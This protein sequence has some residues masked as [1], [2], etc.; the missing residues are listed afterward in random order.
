VVFESYNPGA[1][2]RILED[3]SAEGQI[4]TGPEAV[5]R[6]GRQLHGAMATIEPERRL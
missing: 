3:L 5:D 1:M 4:T 2:A 6:E